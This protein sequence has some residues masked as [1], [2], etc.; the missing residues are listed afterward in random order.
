MIQTWR[1]F[2]N[3]DEISFTDDR[4]DKSKISAMPSHDLHDE[5]PAMRKGRWHDAIYGL[6]DLRSLT[7]VSKS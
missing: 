3:E 4:R 7:N 5:S 1:L 6:D 2:R